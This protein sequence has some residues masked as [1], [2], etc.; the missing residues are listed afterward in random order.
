MLKIAHRGASGYALENSLAAFKKA[1]ELGADM[2]EFDLRC[3]K[4]GELV[5]IHDPHLLRTHK[6]SGWVRNKS[7]TELETLTARRKNKIVTFTEILQTI[8]G[9]AALDIELKEPGTA[10]L[11][12]R[13]LKSFISPTWPWDKFLISSFNHQELLTARRHSNQIR[14]GILYAAWPWGYRSFAKKIRAEAIILN[15]RFLRKALIE[16]A[17]D[18]GLRVFVYTVNSPRAIAK[19]KKWGADGIISNYPDRL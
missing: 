1:I 3:C 5:V 12:L 4:S 19:F 17:H 11:A 6:T 13:T 14:L 8:Q 10:A 7:L 18:S 9:Q 16:Q 2:I 15:H